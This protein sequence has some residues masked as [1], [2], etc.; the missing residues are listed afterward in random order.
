[1]IHNHHEWRESRHSFNRSFS[2]SQSRAGIR[3]EKGKPEN[4]A[5]LTLSSKYMF[6]K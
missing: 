2:L 6:T 3:E 4:V 5:Y 1:M